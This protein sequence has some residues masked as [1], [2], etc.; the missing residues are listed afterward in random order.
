MDA[1]TDRKRNHEALARL[2]RALVDDILTASDESILVEAREEGAD[3]AAMAAAARELFEKAVLASRKTL[4][5]DARASAAADRR[6][7]ADAV[8][9]RDA[10]AARRRLQRLLV[11]H[12]ETA[13]KLTL[14]ARKGRAGDFSD[15]EIFGL[16]EDF[17]DLGIPLP[18][19]DLSGGQ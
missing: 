19:D 7:R 11:Q 2:N 14:A 1:M 12:P 8:Y 4:L 3:P 5:A 10:T 18:E 6:R 9:P 17:E 16:L 15:D 13:Q